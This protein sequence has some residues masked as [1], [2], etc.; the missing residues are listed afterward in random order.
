MIK[1]KN[2]FSLLQL[3]ITYLTFLIK[4][5]FI[6]ALLLLNL[7][8]VIQNKFCIWIKYINKWII[9]IIFLAWNLKLIIINL[10]LQPQNIF[11]IV[12]CHLLLLFLILSLYDLKRLYLRIFLLYCKLFQSEFDI[13]VGI[14]LFLLDSSINFC[15]WNQSSLKK[16]ALTADLI[17]PMY[18]SKNPSLSSIP[19]TFPK[20]QSFSERNAKKNPSN[21]LILKSFYTPIINK[22]SLLSRE[23]SLW[24]TKG[25]Y[26]LQKIESAMK[27][28]LKKII[29]K[30]K[31]EK[32][33]FIVFNKLNKRH[34]NL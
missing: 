32:I 9:K 26:N 1:L 15:K 29:F 12:Y 33:S 8:I 30:S 28:N 14:E 27:K 4:S 16:S 24:K 7:T 25:A 5:G 18:L 13:Q 31:K 20:K 23:K 21:S 22:N 6:T 2:Y 10:S 3:N 34:I 19:G 11:S 17:F